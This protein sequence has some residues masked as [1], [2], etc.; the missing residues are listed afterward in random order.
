MIKCVIVGPSMGVHRTA[1][2]P[3][4][5]SENCSHAPRH[6]LIGKDYFDFGL[7]GDCV[8]YLLLCNF[9]QILRENAI[10][11]WKIAKKKLKK[12]DGMTETGEEVGEWYKDVKGH[13]KI[14]IEMMEIIIINICLII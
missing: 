2:P 13:C 14:R 8:C 7:D 11:L 5:R 12:G 9:R 1:C 10:G 4:R 3:H 6:T